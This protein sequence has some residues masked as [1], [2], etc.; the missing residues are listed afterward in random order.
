MSI[1]CAQLVKSCGRHVSKLEDVNSSEYTFIQLADPQLGLLERYI[2]KREPPF[3]WDREQTLVE[4]ACKIIN[5]MEPKPTFVIVCGDLVDAQPDDPDRFKACADLL[6]ALALLHSN[7][8]VLV[9]PGNHDIGD[10]PRAS[11]LCAYQSMWGDD[12]YSYWCGS[13]KYL[14]VNSQ[15]YWNSSNCSDEAATQDEWL[16][17][18]L[19][20]PENA[21]ASQLIVFQVCIVWCFFKLSTIQHLTI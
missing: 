16:R 2:E 11:D 4:R 12:Y 1:Q 18:E 14:V 21:N 17:T 10:K 7:I 9:L 13:F 15:L 20:A 3:K 8:P 6:S 5:S 19:S